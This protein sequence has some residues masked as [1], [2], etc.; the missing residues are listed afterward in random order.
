MT[1]SISQGA[2]IV[3]GSLGSWSSYPAGPRNSANRNQFSYL[4]DTLLQL[5]CV[6]FAQ[7]LMCQNYNCTHCMNNLAY[8]EKR[9]R[10]YKMKFKKNPTA[11]YPKFG[12][13]ER[14]SKNTEGCNCK[15][16]KCR[17]NY[18]ECYEPRLYCFDLCRCVSCRNRKISSVRKSFVRL[19][20]I[21]SRRSPQPN[22]SGKRLFKTP[23]KM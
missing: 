21:V 19:A 17:K 23:S 3:H 20:A 18:H 9:G 11:F 6:C 15:I 22:A 8:E 13:K 16:S 1:G 7:D 4:K 10:A 5:F 14:E 2:N 12:L